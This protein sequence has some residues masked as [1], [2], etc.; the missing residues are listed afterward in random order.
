[1]SFFVPIFRCNVAEGQRLKTSYFKR[2]KLKP[3]IQLS[4]KNHI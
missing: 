2:E 3:R 1:M 4:G